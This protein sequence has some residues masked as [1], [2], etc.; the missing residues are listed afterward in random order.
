[1]WQRLLLVA[2]SF[3]A[4]LHAN[5]R[6]EYGADSIVSGDIE[7]PTP[8]VRGATALATGVD[9]EAYAG[10]VCRALVFWH[11]L[12]N[13]I[14][15][16]QGR[17]FKVR[18]KGWYAKEKTMRVAFYGTDALP[19]WT[20]KQGLTNIGSKG[21]VDMSYTPV[22][23]EGGKTRTLSVTFIGSDGAE[24]ACSV[25]VR[26]AVAGDV[27]V[28]LPA[29]DPKVCSGRG[30]CSDGDCL[31]DH[32]FGGWDCSG[33]ADCPKN[34]FF[35]FDGGV[36][37]WTP[38][39]HASDNSTW[40]DFATKAQGAGSLRIGN[41]EKRGFIPLLVG[42]HS[43]SGPKLRVI[44]FFM[45]RMFDDH[46]LDN[47]SISFGSCLDLTLT[48]KGGML[49]PS[50][51]R[52]PDG[53]PV[54]ELSKFYAVR[55]DLDWG[56][57]T[58]A[59]SVDGSEPV[60]LP[61][62][63]TCGGIGY[64]ALVG[65]WWLDALQLRC[66]EGEDE[67]EA[68]PCGMDQTCVDPEKTW[69]SLKDFVCTCTNGEKA[70]GAAAECVKDECAAMPAPCGTGQTCNDPDTNTPKD[71]VCTCDSELVAAVGGPAT[72]S[73]DE[74]DDEPCGDEQ[75]CNDPVQSLDSTQDYTC[76]CANSIST[77]GAR[78]LCEKDECASKPCGAGQ[79]CNDPDQ[80][81]NKL[82]DFTCTC[83]EDTAISTT[84]GPATCEK[85]GFSGN[86]PVLPVFVALAAL[87]ALAGA[88]AY[89]VYTRTRAKGAVASVEQLA[90]D[91][92]A[93]DEDMSQLED[94]SIVEDDP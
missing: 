26:V 66:R 51:G 69:T 63:S 42:S 86:T 76:T 90:Q 32:N 52:M 28:G 64:V 24:A 72:C 13:G 70:T 39:E 12:D 2:A 82:Q 36:D 87:C 46:R 65:Y 16:Q 40:L 30:T 17:A 67:C 41:A 23:S 35:P 19:R 34:Y 15:I 84:A 1:M 21:F 62:S 37:G 6:H 91:D 47:S 93:W 61:F 50:K 3:P 81:A 43:Q 78:A 38:S 9:R 75:T 44:T 20:S 88:A 80:A 77:R 71:F 56:A 73:K 14:L 27:C 59:L 49:G 58:F 89:V 55:L 83:D 85:D 94:V 5:P 48:T 4:L 33:F 8:H 53:A 10:P 92:D 60:S 18:F 22:A 68:M 79:M 11:R 25:T 31:C 45:K 29:S 74:C 7:V 57:G 54:L